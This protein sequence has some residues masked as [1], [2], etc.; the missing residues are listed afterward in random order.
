MSKDALPCIVCGARLSNAFPS[1]DNQPSDA[2]AFSSHGHYG[3]TFFDSLDGQ[4]IEI[5]VCDPC[6]SK[7]T[8]RIGWRRAKR[9]I[10]CEGVP[11]GFEY[12]DR[13]LV[14]YTGQD[15]YEEPVTVE[16]EELGKALTRNV[17]WNAAACDEARRIAEIRDAAEG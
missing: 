10:E 17:M 6:L 4:Q 14:P 8:D 11:V 2:T 1:S 16:V 12:L 13:P 7:N 15:E 5:N 3:S 9:S